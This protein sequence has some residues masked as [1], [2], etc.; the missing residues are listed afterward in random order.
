MTTAN[1]LIVSLDVNAL[2]INRDKAVAKLK[3]AYELVVQAKEICTD[4]LVTSISQFGSAISVRGHSNM[5]DST[6][7]VASAT[8]GIDAAAW[9]NLM[10]KSGLRSF[11]D[12]KAK[13][14]WD[15]A[16]YDKKTPPLTL[17]NI[18][19]TFE[20]LHNGR[21]DLF[22]RGVIQIFK[23]LKWDYKTNKPSLFGSKIIVGFICSSKPFVS[24]VHD[25]TNKLD[26]LV[27][28]FSILDGKPEPDHRNGLYGKLSGFVRSTDKELQ[29]EYMNIKIYTG[30]RTA[31]ITFTRPDLV[32][33]LNTII[34]K[35]YGASLPRPN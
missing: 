23:N 28:A 30:T 18:R 3:Q 7:W 31:H 9:Q 21:G 19:S 20:N 24:I 10:T 1:E 17:D 6:D 16:I 34:T 14:E 25:T 5:L 33:K 26:D 4:G 32:D 13:S 22:E 2:L 35:H 12:N 29:T 8:K 27:R 15:S 11:M